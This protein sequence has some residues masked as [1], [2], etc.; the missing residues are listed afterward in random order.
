MKNTNGSKLAPCSSFIIINTSV[1][2][3]EKK[4]N[5]QKYNIPSKDISP[6]NSSMT[7]STPVEGAEL[8]CTV[9]NFCRLYSVHSHMVSDLLWLLWQPA[10]VKKPKINV[11]QYYVFI[12][13]L[14]FTRTKDIHNI[15]EFKL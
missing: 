6:T 13:Y 11:I 1:T 8:P 2:G 15:S 10:K 7:S 5:Q 9:I 3:R 12:I 14:H 4:Q